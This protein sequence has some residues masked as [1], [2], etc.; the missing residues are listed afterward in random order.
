MLSLF[1]KEIRSI[2]SPSAA[3]ISS[4]ILLACPRTH[5]FSSFLSF[6]LLFF[7]SLPPLLIH[8]LPTLIHGSCS[9]N[10]AVCKE[11][12]VEWLSTWLQP[13]WYWVQQPAFIVSAWRQVYLLGEINVYCLEG[14]A[15]SQTTG[16]S[17]LSDSV[18]GNV[19]WLL[20]DQSWPRKISGPKPAEENL[21]ASSIFLCTAITLHCAKRKNNIQ[22]HCPWN[23]LLGKHLITEGWLQGHGGLW[24]CDCGQR[25]LS[26][27]WG[28]L[29]R[30]DEGLCLSARVWQA[31]CVKSGEGW[32]RMVSLM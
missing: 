27:P 25:G 28:L 22:A 31:L 9:V 26:L 2:L 6:P 14:G 3:S 23:D 16:A 20:G 12:I 1:F 10:E 24:V 7:L 32:G 8:L 18:K 11:L 5:A 19:S 17:S 4:P 30:D 21:P 15:E 29:R 13:G